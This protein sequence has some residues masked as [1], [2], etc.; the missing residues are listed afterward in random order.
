MRNLRCAA[1]TQLL[2]TGSNRSRAALAISR[3]E[4]STMLIGLV[5]RGA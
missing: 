5:S 3:L 1:A 2:N 4:V